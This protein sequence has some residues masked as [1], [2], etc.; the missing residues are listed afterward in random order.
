MTITVSGQRHR[1]FPAETLTANRQ[2]TLS[3][4]GAVA[5]DE[6]FITRNDAT[7]FTLTITNGGVGGGT[8]AVMPVSTRAWCLASFDGTNWFHS[9]SGLA[10]A[11]T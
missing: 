11:A 3:T 4:T 1:V 9:A 6:L 8:L 10:L 2:I 7:T 5:G